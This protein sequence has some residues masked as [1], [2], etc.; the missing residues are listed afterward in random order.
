MPVRLSAAVC[1]HVMNIYLH[2][3]MLVNMVNTMMYSEE[4]ITHT[5]TL[6]EHKLKAAYLCNALG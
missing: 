3:Q 6:D 1:Y 2:T 5:K 4:K